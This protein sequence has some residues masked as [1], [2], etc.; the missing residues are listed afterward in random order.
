MGKGFEVRVQLADIGQQHIEVFILVWWSL[1]HSDNKNLL[2]IRVD[3]VYDPPALNAQPP[4]FAVVCQLD[5]KSF[6]GGREGSGS[7]IKNGAAHTLPNMTRQ[8]I[9]LF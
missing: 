3:H 2:A 5:C 7:Q 9:D 8:L 1:A 6:A 4:A